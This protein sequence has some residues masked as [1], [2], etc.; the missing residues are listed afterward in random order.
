[1]VVSIN[2][3]RGRSGYCAKIDRLIE[4]DGLRI[5]WGLLAYG[6]NGRD[7]LQTPALADEELGLAGDGVLEPAPYVSVG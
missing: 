3:L 1:M 4:R 6:E 7:R 2:F 5:Q